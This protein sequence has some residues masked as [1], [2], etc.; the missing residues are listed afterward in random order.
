MHVFRFNPRSRCNNSSRCC[1][2]AREMY[3]DICLL[4]NYK[5]KYFWRD[6][7]PKSLLPPSFPWI[8]HPTD[9]RSCKRCGRKLQ[10]YETDIIQYFVH[11]WSYQHHSALHEKGVPPRCN[12]KWTGHEKLVGTGNTCKVPPRDVHG[13]F[14]GYEKLVH[15]D[16]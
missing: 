7:L 1:Y 15:T 12:T 5:A 8:V 13:G 2:R 11:Q 10:Q 16:W 4:I 14:T 3:T 9:K 6:G